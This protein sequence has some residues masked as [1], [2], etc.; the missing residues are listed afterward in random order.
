M[1][2]CRRCLTKVFRRSKDPEWFEG[3]EDCN[4]YCDNCDSFL[5]IDGVAHAVIIN[6]DGKRTYFDLQANPKTGD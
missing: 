3:I 5:T 2:I 6:G 4:Y 1:A